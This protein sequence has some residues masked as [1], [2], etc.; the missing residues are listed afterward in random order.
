MM[1]RECSWLD[2]SYQ[3]QNTFVRT[4]CYQLDPHHGLGI[5]MPELLP[6]PIFRPRKDE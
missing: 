6:V 1:D 2:S 5:V 4:G 3:L